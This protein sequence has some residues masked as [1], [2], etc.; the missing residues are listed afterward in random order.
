[1]A[2][3]HINPQMTASS[4]YVTFSA[5][6][7]QT[8]RNAVI[9][10]ERP[11]SEEEVWREI[12]TLKEAAIA[13]WSDSRPLSPAARLLVDLFLPL[14]ATVPASSDRPVV[15]AH[16]AQS[17]DGRIATLDG[18][19]QWITGKQDVRH[20][21]RLRAV[22]DVV[23]VGAETVR[24][25]NPRLTVRNVCGENPLRL[26]ID[27]DRR[28]DDS[29]HLFAD[30]AA[31]TLLVC[32]GDRDDGGAVG[33]ASVLGV[34]RGDGGLDLADLLR[35]LTARGVRRLFVEGGGITVSR[36]LQA[37]YLDRLHLVMAPVILG[38][39]R[40]GLI[41]PEI[42]GLHRALRPPTRSFSMGESV[43]F[44]CRFHG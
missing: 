19:S 42:Q 14:L 26:V 28:L 18:E 1:M 6:Q 23:V 27:P 5:R 22:A 40:P 39:G 29:Y 25:D 34:R 43:L 41:L 15:F 16:L 7:E 24:Q 36:F 44:D 9:V 35:R 11:L 31:E 2:R 10:K 17:L 33:K 13:R 12:L 8:K 32:D 20:T 21:H 4:L 37:G 3:T 38:V 30:G